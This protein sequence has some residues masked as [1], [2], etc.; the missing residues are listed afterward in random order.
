MQVHPDLSLME[1]L[2]VHQMDEMITNKIVG[3]EQMANMLLLFHQ[4]VREPF[5]KERSVTA[6]TWLLLIAIAF[7][8]MIRWCGCWM[9]P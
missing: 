6:A 5:C 8:D 4:E 9:V 1:K 7:A 2:H 3:T